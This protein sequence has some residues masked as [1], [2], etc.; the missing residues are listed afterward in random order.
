MQNSKAYDYLIKQLNASGSEKK[1]GYYPRL[2]EDI[3][4]CER[5]KVEDIIW[6]AYFNKKEIEMAQFF[7]KLKKYDGIKALKESGKIIRVGSDRKGYWKI[8]R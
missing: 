5:E 7:P 6:D 3:Y 1:D 2:M 4:D 8:I